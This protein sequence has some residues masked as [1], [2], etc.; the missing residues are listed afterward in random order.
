LVLEEMKIMKVVLVGVFNNKHE[1]AKIKN[2]GLEACKN[3]FIKISF[4]DGSH[5]PN[6][7]IIL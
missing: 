7:S 5:K 1:A 3:C 2:A 4:I 6:H